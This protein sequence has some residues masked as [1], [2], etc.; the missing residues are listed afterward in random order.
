V[1]G[2]PNMKSDNIAYLA[3]KALK[4]II[5][6]SDSKEEAQSVLNVLRGPGAIEAMKDLTVFERLK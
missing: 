1:P 6:N 3:V 4:W 5:E 2:L